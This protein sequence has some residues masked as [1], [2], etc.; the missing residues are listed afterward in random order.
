LEKKLKYVEFLLQNVKR[1]G[2]AKQNQKQEPEVIDEDSYNY[3]SDTELS[4]KQLVLRHI[5]RIS[6]YIFK[7]E[8]Q[9]TLT[10]RTI[11]T[12]RRQILIQAIEYLTALLIPYYDEE[13]KKEQK[14]F[15]EVLSKIEQELM[16]SSI[17][18]E[19]YNRA[20][21]SQG[22]FDKAVKDWKL[23]LK[24]MKIMPIDKASGNYELSM[25]RTFKLYMDLFKELNFLLHRL[26]YLSSEAY[27]E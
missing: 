26:D 23:Y 10:E 15:D 19:A 20:R 22:N 21:K 4:P 7:G 25:S 9:P 24:Q 2:M 17:N 18:T 14:G 12:D 3:S 8:Q 6:K 5:D 13:M 11:T 1:S 16:I 27:T